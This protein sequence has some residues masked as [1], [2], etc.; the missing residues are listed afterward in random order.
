[1]VLVLPLLVNKEH[2]SCRLNGLG[3]IQR[4]IRCK[5]LVVRYVLAKKV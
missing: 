1:M 3:I 2:S 5:N 4:N